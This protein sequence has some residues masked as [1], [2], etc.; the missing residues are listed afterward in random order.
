MKTKALNSIL[1]GIV[2]GGAFFFVTLSYPVVGL[3][4]TAPKTA[5]AATA[6]SPLAPPP[7]PAIEGTTTAT[8]SG[9]GTAPTSGSEVTLET[10]LRSASARN[11]QIQEAQ[12]DVEIARA[13]LDR[14]RAAIY[15]RMEATIIGAPI[16][17][18]TGDALRVQDNWGKWGPFL[19]GGIQAIQPIYT[20]GQIGSYKKAAEHQIAAREGQTEMKR[21]EVLGTLKETYYGY[22]LATDL[23]RLV[24]D[25]SKFLGEAVDE[26]EEQAKKKKKGGVKPHDLFRLKTSLDDLQQK[27]LFAS[28]AKQTAEKALNWMAVVNVDKIPTPRLS[29]VAFEKKTLE[30]YLAIAKASR[31]E[32]KALSEG[33]AARHALADAKRAQS[34]PVIFIGAFFSQAWSPVRTPQ[35]SFF[36][37]D[38][39]NRTEGGGGLGVRFDLEFWRH[40]AEAAEERAQAMKLKATESYA[41]PGI[42]LQVRKAYYEM[43][44]SVASVEIAERRRQ[45]SKKWFVQ[46]AMGW[47]IGITPPKELLEALEGDG[48]SRKNYAET[49]YM[50]NLA[51]T[52]LSQAVGKEVTSLN[53]K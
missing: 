26:A 6:N 52:R 48:L 9:S 46:S 42:E 18:Q 28:A 3:A 15:P 12:G 41:I 7:A 51:L 39:F 45:T 14:A 44:Q 23:E 11:A 2:T 30:E 53:Y 17:E 16:Y 31:P 20:F 34:Y 32:F 47:S 27:K 10:L 43:E 5:P 29:P 13:Q 36:A 40:G 8:V 19:K 38:P 33:Q 22:L 35:K 1:K 37:N 50:H 49:I 21:L 4:E 24:D 25:L